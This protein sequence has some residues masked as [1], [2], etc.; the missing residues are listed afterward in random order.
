MREALVLILFLGFEGK[1]KPATQQTEPPSIPVAAFFPNGMY[2]E[3]ERQPYK[4][5]Y[6]T[7]ICPCDNHSEIL[8]SQSLRNS[9]GSDA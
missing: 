7:L 6:G 4:D 3:G 2:P 5:E 9:T 1:M 8:A